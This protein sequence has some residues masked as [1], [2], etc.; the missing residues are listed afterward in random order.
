MIIKCLFYDRLKYVN[1]RK[2]FGFMA[3]PIQERKTD[4]IG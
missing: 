2:L 4:T 3:K 1:Y